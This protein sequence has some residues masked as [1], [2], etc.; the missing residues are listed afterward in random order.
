MEK[1]ITSSRRYNEGTSESSEGASRATPA[2]S[3]APLAAASGMRAP[4]VTASSRPR[5]S[6]CR[7][8]S[9]VNTIWRPRSAT[10][11]LSELK[12]MA[13]WNSP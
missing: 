7:A 8:A 6:R 3:T 11:E 1:D 2:A 4:R 10:I 5:R 12:T 13:V 9:R